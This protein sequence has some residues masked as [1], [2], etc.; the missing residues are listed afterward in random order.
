MKKKKKGIIIVTSITQ[1]LLDMLPDDPSDM[2]EEE[3]HK[4]VLAVFRRCVRYEGDPLDVSKLPKDYDEDELT[5]D[6]DTVI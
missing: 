1:D 2:T 5:Y 6:P 4:F 3:I